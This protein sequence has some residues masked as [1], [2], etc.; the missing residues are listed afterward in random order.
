MTAKLRI[1]IVEDNAIAAKVLRNH[2]LKAG[3]AVD[4]ATGAKAA[5][6]FLLQKHYRLILMD[7][8]LADGDGRT[9]TQW[10]REEKNLNQSTAII[11]ISAHMDETLKHACLAA[12]AN[13][14]LV[15]P[16]SRIILDKLLRD[17]Q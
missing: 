6:K 10:I 13:E 8:G 5:L 16:V 2:C 17:N 9:L 11:V 14:V 12:G 1:L 15:K 7:L 3:F 4:H